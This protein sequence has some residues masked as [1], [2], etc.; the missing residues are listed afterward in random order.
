MEYKTSNLAHARTVNL[1]EDLKLKRSFTLIDLHR[2]DLEK[3]IKNE[4]FEQKRVAFKLKCDVRNLK[5]DTSGSVEETKENKKVRGRKKT[6][7]KFDSLMS[8]CQSSGYCSID[9][10]KG[11]AQIDNITHGKTVDLPKIVTELKNEL[12]Q[13]GLL[14]NELKNL[15]DSEVRLPPIPVFNNGVQDAKANLDETGDKNSDTNDEKADTNNLDANKKPLRKKDRI[16]KLFPDILTPRMKTNLP[17]AQKRDEKI[18]KK[19]LLEYSQRMITVRDYWVGD[20]MAIGSVR[21]PRK[22][23]TEMNSRK[24]SMGPV[25]KLIREFPIGCTRNCDNPGSKLESL[26]SSQPSF[27]PASKFAAQRKAFQLKKLSE[28]PIPSDKLMDETALKTER[29]GT[30]E[31]TSGGIERQVQPKI[32]SGFD[33]KYL[34]STFRKNA[35]MKAAEKRQDFQKKSKEIQKRMKLVRHRSSVK[36]AENFVVDVNKT[37]RVQVGYTFNPL[38][39]KAGDDDRL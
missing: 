33:L 39:S 12:L 22:N 9:S 15:P 17:I 37:T 6:M 1:L 23:I 34:T 31:K 3:N 11:F 38:K 30:I 32:I 14:S 21:R 13:T 2:A 25:H 28:K 26:V 4:I 36:P 29:Q 8:L 35:M 19:S 27:V 10:E 24:K 7:K 18:K 20:P 5:K 16:T